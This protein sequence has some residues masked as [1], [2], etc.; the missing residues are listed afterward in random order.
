M[1]DAPRVLGPYELLSP[2]GQGGMGRVFRAR[3]AK[4]GQEVALKTVQA[5]SQASLHGIRREIQALARLRHPGV[6]RI[7]DEG[8]HDGLPWYAMELLAG[9][10]LTAWR[11]SLEETR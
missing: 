2:L 3:H 10:T 9:R 11:A 8:L 7:L 4:T 1:S 6:V 5:P